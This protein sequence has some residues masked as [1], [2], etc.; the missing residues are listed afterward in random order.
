M[1][2]IVDTYELSAMQAAMLFHGVSGEDPGLYIDQVTAETCF[3]RARQ[4]VAE[5]HSVL[6]SRF[7]CEGVGN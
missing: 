7:C 6:R 1:T 4:Q 5:R 2:R 3:L